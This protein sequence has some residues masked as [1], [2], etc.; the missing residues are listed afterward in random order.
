MHL[1]LYADEFDFE[2]FVTAPPG[3]GSARD[4]HD[5]IDEYEKDYSNLITYSDYP[6]PDE[7][8]S[9][10]KSGA[11]SCNNSYGANWIVQCA[12]KDDPR[13]LYIIV[14]G[15]ITNIS[16]AIKA[17][18]SIAEKIRIH[19]IAGW[20]QN[21]CTEDVG[22]L[23]DFNKENRDKLWLIHDRETFRGVQKCFPDEGCYKINF[24]DCHVKGHG[25][26]GDYYGTLDHGWRIK[27]GD[28]PTYMRLLKCADLD[29]PTTESWGGQ[30]KRK[31]GFAHYYQ[32]SA[33]ADADLCPSPRGAVSVA[34][35]HKEW[36]DDW[37][38]RQDR[39]LAPFDGQVYSESAAAKTMRL[40]IDFT[41]TDNNLL[42][43]NADTTPASVK[44]F[45]ANG[46]VLI[47]HYGCK[48][49]YALNGINESV[50]LIQISQ[51]DRSVLRKIVG[52]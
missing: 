37:E 33:F 26:M 15:A 30:F 21:H 43:R 9:L 42:V 7:L 24:P 18:P 41:I 34:K 35:W 45:S 31:E 2:G 22:F 50:I 6:T 38:K 14:W 28:T 8:R 46:R 40:P 12:K 16:Q 20:N 3:A 47:Q 1:L 10:V 17:D 11:G 19:W 25:A 13:P 29:D 36:L 49:I 27:M 48:Q 39:C 4:F 44:I 32:D 51:G 52:F 23:M 5:V